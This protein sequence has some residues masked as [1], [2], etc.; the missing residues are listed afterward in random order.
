MADEL[1]IGVDIGTQGVKC[2]VFDESG[3]CLATS[4]L[5]SELYQPETGI[6]EED[7]EFQLEGV[8]R[9]ISECV[10]TIG[11]TR[12]S[13]IRCLAIDGQMA[14]IIGIGEDGMAVTPY[15]SWL[16]TRCAPYITEMKEQAED[17]I[18]MKTGSPPSFNHGPKILW[19]KQE[20]PDTYRRI[21]KF[22]QPG[23]YAAMRLC[24]MTAHDAFIDVTYLNFSGFADNP[25]RRWDPSLIG[26]FDIDGD[27][28]PRI[29]RPADIVGEMTPDMA[30]RCGLMKPVAVAAGCGDS[31]ASFLSCG[32]VRPGICVNAAGTSSVF[33]ATTDRF[34]YD[35]KSRMIGCQAS[36]EDGLWHPHAYINGGGMN[37]EWFVTDVLGRDKSDSKRFTDLESDALEPE[38]SDPFFVPHMAGR[39]CPSQPDMQGT[40]AGLSWSHSR[41]QM[42]RAVMEGVALEYGLY[43]RAIRT[44]APDTEINEL[45]ITGGGE[46]S[47]LWNLM[48]SSVLQVPV[49]PIAQGHGAPMGAAI[50]A[51][52]GSGLFSSAAEAA[53][54]WITLK[55]PIESDAEIW[56][57]YER[58]VDKYQSLLD[59]MNRYYSED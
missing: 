45:R 19:W 49:V 57:F 46:K 27:K 12:A 1:L 47:R 54:R 33:T 13:D 44:I 52:V 41:K 16:D 39:V 48:K 26:S 37:L 20:R 5:A 14:G 35:V 23:G 24:G 38:M 21:A 36:V 8:C 53:D 30:N 9:T 58:R 34:V 51:G 6:T 29:V 59:S 55:S 31:G 17:E 43:L 10:G 40:F 15:D 22:V 2:S 18:I 4:F 42:F 7:P 50:I 56:P 25:G 32:A 11:E 28:L 3:S